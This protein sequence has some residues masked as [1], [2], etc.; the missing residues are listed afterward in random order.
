M[1]EVVE[2]GTIA[3][4]EEQQRQSKVDHGGKIWN[5]LI[6]FSVKPPLTLP[7]SL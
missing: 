7:I 2:Q 3:D 4:G 1:E 6:L 5:F